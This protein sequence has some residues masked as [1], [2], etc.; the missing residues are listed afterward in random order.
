MKL[1]LVTPTLNAA[2]YLPE[3]LASV[4]SQQWHDLEHIV[5]DGGSTDATLD[6]LRAE[7]N[8]VVVSEP[9][10]GLYD[11]INKGIAMATGDDRRISQR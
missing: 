6:I 2:T 7:P 9:D 11:A 10:G 1:T 3:A 8:L 5:V 4:R